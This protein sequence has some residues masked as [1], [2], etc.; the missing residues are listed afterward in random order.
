MQSGQTYDVAV[1][2][3]VNGVL[4]QLQIITGGG[5]TTG[6]GGCG[7]APG[8]ALLNDSMAGTGKT[9]TVPASFTGAHVD[10]VLTGF[11]GAGNGQYSGGKGGAFTD[12]GGGGANVVVVKGFPCTSGY[13]FTYTLPSAVGSDATVT[14]TGL[15]LV[16]HPG[17]NA[18]TVADGTGGPNTGTQTAT[19]AT[20]VTSYAGHNGGLTDTWDGGGPGATINVASGTVTNPGP[21]NTA[22]GTPGTIPGQGGA[23]SIYY[24]VQAGGGCNLLIIAR[25]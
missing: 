21:D 11:P 6:S 9:F 20:S 1:A 8:T 5:T 15:S 2:Y 13:V 17:T 14:G 23:G 24:G 16:A 22:Q 7:G 10:I 3:V 4:G 25:A 18:T 12:T 19:G